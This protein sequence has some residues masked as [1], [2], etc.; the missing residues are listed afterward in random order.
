MAEKVDS[1]PHLF[2]RCKE[3]R[4]GGHT[5]E[6]LRLLREAVRRRTLAPEEFV[7][8]GRLIA[9]SL[10]GAEATP[11]VVT[12]LLLGQC[13]TSWLVPTLT[14][15]AFGRRG[16]VVAHDA[17]YDNIIQHLMQMSERPDVIV[18]LPWHQR[19]L[20]NPD[21]P[22][23]ERLA[24]ELEFLAHAW[25]L[26]RQSG[27]RLVQVG[28]DW[29][30]PGSFGYHLGGH[31]NGDV[32]LVRQLNE[33]VRNA[34]PEGAYFVDLEQLS[35]TIGHHAFYD[36]RAYYWTKQPFS[37]RGL[38]R[39][40][41][42]LWAGIR[43]VT[44][45]PKKVLVLDLDNTLWG[46]VVG[47]VGPLG[48]GV[49]DTPEGEAY[50]AFQRH[51]KML[52]ERGVLLVVCSKN[53]VA[54]ARE[55]FESHHDMILSLTDFAVF[56]ASWEPKPVLIARIAETLKLGLDS[57]VFFDDSPSEREY[58]RQSLPDVEV[59][60]VPT[61]PADYVCAL[62]EGL[63]FEALA[64]TEADRQRGHQYRDESQRRQL[65]AAAGTLS[66]YLAS[67]E[68]RAEIRPID[69]LD[70]DRVVQLL[71]KTNQF[72][73]TTRRH[74]AD[75]VRRMA[76]TPGAVAL[77]LRLKDRF[78]DYGLISVAIGVPLPSAPVPTLR[79][80]TWLMSCRAIGR[81]AEEYLMKHVIEI[82]RRLNY[83]VLIGEFIQTSKNALVADFY[84]RLGFRPLPA[85]GDV[86]RYSIDVA[87]FTPPRSF[88]APED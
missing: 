73:L 14:A 54:D 29:V 79:L 43:A 26:V 88:V 63:W 4:R 7:Q 71:A 18:L 50:R 81:T 22:P 13:T 40:G 55:P 86:K 12:V 82:A 41:E 32:W 70:M 44:T 85:T 17:Q 1:A 2:R 83:D 67:L 23:R 80:D 15:V 60:E 78:G 6:A 72:N 64:I 76:G 34:L 51:V 21:R 59:V 19:L 47:E 66:H 84:E 69:E 24:D 75:A 8:A 16:A 36:A 62:Q 9:T 10:A 28:Y 77:T 87:D 39:L 3:L 49:G 35:A 57:F 58:V 42:H 61:D 74:D 27:S 65:Q 53:N 38:V 25:A 30:I 20:N 46:G 45:G 5:S 68:M 52:S 11:G 48:I 56:E 31:P 33:A 37:P